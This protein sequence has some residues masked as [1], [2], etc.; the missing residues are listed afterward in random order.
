M[1]KKKTMCPLLKQTAYCNVKYK[2]YTFM[3]VDR[4]LRA[5]YP[6]N[7]RLMLER[8]WRCFYFPPPPFRPV[9]RSIQPPV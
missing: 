8:V 7:L 3:C 4:E 5:G 1:Q 2:L 6:V 9:V